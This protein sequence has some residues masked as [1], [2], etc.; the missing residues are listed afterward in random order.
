MEHPPVVRRKDLGASEPVVIEPELAR[1]ASRRT[2]EILLVTF[3]V[4]CAIEGLVIGLL[5]DVP[6]IG[7][8]I[9]ATYAVFYFFLGREFGDGWLVR[10]CRAKPLD[11]ARI[12]RLVAGEARTAGIPA[13]RLLL[14]PGS[15]P[16]AFAF[17]LRRRWLVVTTP[18]DAGDELALEGMFAHEVIHLRDGDASIAGLF[19]ILAGAPDLVLRRAGVLALLSIPI[20]PVSLAMR[21]TARAALPEEREIRADIAGALLTRYPPGIVAALREAGGGPSPLRVSDPFWFVPRG[22]R[23]GPD[24]AR[25]A[26]L[27]EEM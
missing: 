24:A 11:S 22:N 4:L 6:L 19:A 17:A 25:R 3:V 15:K 20:W 21:L 2:I 9:G 18:T 13:P 14:A 16:N 8:A 23:H 27:L 7:S 5:L 1:K 10:A 12:S 26:E